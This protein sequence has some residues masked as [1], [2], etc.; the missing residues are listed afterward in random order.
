MIFPGLLARKIVSASGNIKGGRALGGRGL[1]VTYTIN[2]DVLL[3]YHPDYLAPENPEQKGKQND[4]QY[5]EQKRELLQ[6]STSSFS[7]LN[8]MNSD[9]SLIPKEKKGVEIQAVAGTT[10][11]Q[12][13]RLP[14]PV[15][16]SSTFLLPN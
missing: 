8:S 11:R 14:V 7:P 12:S 6:A 3:T 4:E 10:F 5:G 15:L 2:R 13:F 1:R 9:S 16:A